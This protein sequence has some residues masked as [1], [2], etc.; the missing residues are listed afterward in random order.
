MDDAVVPS[1]SQTPV[2]AGHL[3]YRSGDSNTNNYSQNAETIIG[4][5]L[6]DERNAEYFGPQLR[7]TSRE[8]SVSRLVSSLRWLFVGW[9][10]ASIVKVLQALK[11]NGTR[12]STVISGLVA[13]WEPRHVAELL[14]LFYFLPGGCVRKR[15]AAYHILESL[16]R[17]KALTIISY[18]HNFTNTA[19][20]HFT[21]NTIRN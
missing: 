11:L 2:A 6:R 4:L 10:M 3:Q 17:Q 20:R 1:R 8:Y 9:R 7:R 15:R 12:E 13:D 14:A 21:P 5:W 18:L 19:T 16:S